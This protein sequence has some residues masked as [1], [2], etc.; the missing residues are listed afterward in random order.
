MHIATSFI[1]YNSIMGDDSILSLDFAQNPIATITE[2]SLAVRNKGAIVTNAQTRFSKKLH[3][4][5][6]PGFAALK[7][8]D[9]LVA[10][11]AALDISG[12]LTLYSRFNEQDRLGQGAQFL[13]TSGDVLYS[14]NCAEEV[15]FLVVAVKR[16]LF[17]FGEDGSLDL[18]SPKSWQQIHDMYLEVVALRHKALRSH[19]NIVRLLG[20]ALDG[21]WYQ[22]PLLVLELAFADL[23]TVFEKTQLGYD[24]IHQLGIDV[25]QGLDAI[26]GAGIVHGDLK[27]QNVLVFQNDSARVPF[28]AKLADFGLSMD[29]DKA[30]AGDLVD[31]IGMS[32]EWCAPEIYHGVKFVPSQLI[33]ADNFSYGMVLWSISCLEGQSP[34]SKH[35]QQALKSVECCEGLSNDL[36]SQVAGALSF[37]LHESA[38]DRPLRVG[39][40]LKDDS[41]AGNLWSALDSFCKCSAFVA[42]QH[43]DRR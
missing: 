42:D 24:A 3:G 17:N 20:W 13:V 10:S 21:S 32:S 19:R 33:K 40:L 41:V 12:P 27:P 15:N 23:R 37:L 2:T 14:E 26:H 11:L 28:V 25:G 36:A 8:I 30:T 35:V 22:M 31:V 4:R 29:D 1:I 5:S 9:D 7:T 38:V 43:Q 18:T 34:P 16:P 39:G 6:L